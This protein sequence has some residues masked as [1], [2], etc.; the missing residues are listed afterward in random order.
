MNT[1]LKNKGTYPDMY[2][3]LGMYTNE[4]LDDYIPVLKIYS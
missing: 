3:Y 4:H 1:Q 2:A